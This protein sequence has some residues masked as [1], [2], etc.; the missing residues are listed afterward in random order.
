[1]HAL[2]LRQLR[3]LVVLSETRNFTRAAEACFVTQSTLSAG[4]KELET[5]LGVQLVE[6]DR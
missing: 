2:S 3:Y 6:R 4:L 5:T 1:M